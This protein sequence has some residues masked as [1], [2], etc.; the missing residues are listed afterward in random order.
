MEKMKFMRENWHKFVKLTKREQ[1]VLRLLVKGLQH[2]EI[3]EKL[4]I[5]DKTV[6]THRR[7]IINKLG[8]KHMV[9]LYRFADTFGLI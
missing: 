9:D 7:N 6:K 8:C 5:S 1:S 4:F 2:S 3:S